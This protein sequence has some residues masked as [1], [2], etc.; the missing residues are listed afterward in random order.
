MK[1]ARIS[2]GFLAGTLV[3]AGYAAGA[4]PSPG[5]DTGIGVTRP[6][7]ALRFIALRAGHGTLVEAV[8]VRGGRIL[9]SRYLEGRYGVPLVTYGGDTGGLARRAP[10]LVLASATGRETTRFLV[11]DPRTLKVRAR[12]A[13]RGAFAFDALSPGG[14]VMYL[15]EFREGVNSVHY[16]VR[17]FNLDTRRLYPGAIVDRRE[18]DEKMNGIPVTRVESGQGSWAYTLYARG[19]AKPFVHAL[20]TLHRRAFCIDVPLPANTD[21]LWKVRM[22]MEPGRVVLVRK[23]ETLASFDTK[24]FEVRRG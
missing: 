9:R 24:T 10:R 11:L 8:R 4:G 17:A 20:D 22:R 6:G 15:L 13:L 18:P 1:L 3:L 7:G 21:W 12:I 19:E 23:G 2:A 16:A 14:S 5:L